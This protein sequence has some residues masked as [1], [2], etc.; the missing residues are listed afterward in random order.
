MAYIHII[1]SSSPTYNNIIINYTI[2][3]LCSNN[4]KLY[5]KSHITL[6]S[7]NINLIKILF[8]KN[9]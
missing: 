2:I 8:T 1:Y 7:T 4:I 6:R 3:N 9:K 5:K